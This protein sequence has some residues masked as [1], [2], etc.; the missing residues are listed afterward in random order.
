MCKYIKLFVLLILFSQL[1]SKTL[2]VGQNQMFSDLKTAVKIAVDYDT[3]IVFSGYYKLNKLN[4]NKPLT[5]LGK[6]NPILDATN[7]SELIVINSDSVTLKGFTLQNIPN[8]FTEDWAAIRLNKSRYCLIEDNHIYNSFFGIYLNRSLNC[9]IKHN[10]IIGKAKKEFDAGNA[11]HLWY[12][13]N[14]LIENNYAGKHRDGIYLE[15]TKNSRIVFNTSENNLRYGLHFMFCDNNVYKKNIFRFNG[16]G[17]A[18]MFSKN[19][20]MHSNVFSDNIGSSSYGLLL[21]DI[22]D[23]KITK[24]IIK[25]NTIGIHADGASRC[26]IKNNEF[27][28]NGW[29]IRIL[30]S[31]V[32]DTIFENNFFSNSFDISTNSTFNKNYYINNYW[33]KYTGYDLDKDGI[34]DIPYRPVKLFSYITANSKESLILLRSFFVTL[35]EFA[36]SI[37]PIFTPQNLIDN[38]PLM[39]PVKCWK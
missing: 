12:S 13:D 31:S 35:I 34:G 6:N 27:S 16:A 3:I 11:I 21:K 38:Y 14:A 20:N 7:K 23:S 39:N 30:G 9:M 36:E 1:Q 24:N 4:I 28:K 5:I 26:F 33:S 25:N 19:V 29:A 17:V 10:K 8:N 37:S 32:N 18:V 2:T 22:V 15:F